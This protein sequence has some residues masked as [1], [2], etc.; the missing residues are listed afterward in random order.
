MIDLSGTID[1]HVHSAPDVYPRLL[2]DLAVVRAAE[3]AGMRG[4]LLKSHHTLTADRATLVGQH[5]RI[6]VRGGLAL[7]LTVGGLNPVAVEAAIAFGARQIWMPTIHARHCLRMAEV[8]M[9]AVEARKG[10]A[11]IAPFDDQGN[12]VAPLRAILEMIRDAD[13]VLGTGHLAPEESLALIKLAHDMNVSRI[14]VTHPLMSFTLFTLDQMKQASDWG[15][16]LEFDAL[17]CNSKW[18]KSMPAETTAQAIAEVGPRHC[19][20][21]SDGGQTWNP[22]APAMLLAFAE[23]LSE[24]GIADDALRCMMQDNPTY[25]LGL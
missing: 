18:P 3:Q 13:V 12:P 1:L 16:L 2:D 7:N 23:E 11:G 24:C 22:A 17:S 4:V 25:L 10:Y 15:A 6:A 20:L 19:V 14:L 21:A 5:T 8:E 9:F